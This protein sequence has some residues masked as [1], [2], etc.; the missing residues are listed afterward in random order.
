MKMPWDNKTTSQKQ[1]K[2]RNPKNNNP[3]GKGG[4]A[5]HPE[6]INGKG[7][8]LKGNTIQELLHEASQQ[9]YAGEITKGMQV[10][11]NIVDGAVDGDKDFIKI[12]LDRHFGKAAETINL[13]QKPKLDMSKYT[14]DEL[15]ALK[16]L[17]KKQEDDDTDD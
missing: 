1:V 10:I 8:P 6:N 12:Y 16:G 15:V 4:F 14:D 2:K 5:D 11:Y 9:I 7:R 17:L 13:Y 3:S